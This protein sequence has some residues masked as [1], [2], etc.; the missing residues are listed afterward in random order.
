M[1]IL[2]IITVIATLIILVRLFRLPILRWLMR[3]RAKLQIHS[4]RK[5]IK[6]ADTDKESTGRKNMVVFNK[7]SGKYEPLQKRLLKAAAKSGKNKSNK[8]MTEGRI[9]MLRTKKPRVFDTDRVKQ[10]EKKS[11]YVT[12]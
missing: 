1:K 7:H 8:A 6:D 3:L 4:L 12:D 5:A 11:L 9:K 2:L 10:I